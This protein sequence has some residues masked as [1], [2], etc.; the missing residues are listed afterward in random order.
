[1]DLIK[2][3][4]VS[5]AIQYRRSVRVFKN[6]GLDSEKVKECIRLATLAP[7]SSNMQLWEFYQITT[8][9][10]LEKLALASFNQN[11]AKTAKQMVVVVVRKDLWRKRIRSNV[12]FLKSQY[13]EKSPLDY[14][15][16]EKF[17]LNYYQKIVPTLYFDFLGVLGTLK[18][19]IFQT[20]GLFKPIYRQARKSDMRIVA[21]KSAAL[22]AQNFMISMAAVNYDTC[23]MEGFDS[24]RVKKILN[25]PAAAEVNMIIG[26]GIREESGVYGERFRIPFEEVYFKL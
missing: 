12:A 13:G 23:P 26:C 7:T 16:R 1:M 19:V 22:A 6:E 25:L 14:S 10:V 2:E 17:A 18:F 24:L 15:K 20:I 4:S 9:E 5:A 21:H 8:S 3:R 11:A